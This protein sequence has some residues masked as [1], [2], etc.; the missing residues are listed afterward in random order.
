MILSIVF[1]LAI[2]VVGQFV[3]MSNET[4]A[5]AVAKESFYEKISGHS[6]A[7]QIQKIRYEFNCQEGFSPYIGVFTNPRQTGFSET[8]E[9]EIENLVKQDIL[10]STGY[11]D[12]IVLINATGTC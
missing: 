8:Q 3:N 1:L 7:L 9:T 6:K 2:V 12:I 4:I 10:S 11:N 5:L